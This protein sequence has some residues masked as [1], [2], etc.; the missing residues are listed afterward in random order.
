MYKDYAISFFLSFTHAL[1]VN[2]SAPHKTILVQLIRNG[3]AMSVVDCYKVRTYLCGCVGACVNKKTKA[4][5]TTGGCVC[6]RGGFVVVDIPA[7]WN[8]TEPRG[9]G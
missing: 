1:Q 5:A 6:V 9:G 8:E 7:P 3:A 4:R 2:L